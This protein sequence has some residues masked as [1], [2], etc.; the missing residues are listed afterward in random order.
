MWTGMTRAHHARDGLALPSDLTDTEW[1]L[2]EP[3]VPSRRRV[4]RSARWSLRRIVEALMYLLCGGLPWRML[5]PRIFLPVA[6]VQHYFYLWLDMGVG[7]VRGKSA[8][9]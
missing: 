9:R 1:A 3:L 5:P 7:T 2:I 4:G 6:T 8:C